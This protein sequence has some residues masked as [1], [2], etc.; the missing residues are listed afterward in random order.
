MNGI[1]EALATWAAACRYDD[2]P[3]TVLERARLQVASVLASVFA[4]ARTEAGRRVLDAAQT[5]GGGAD[6]RVLPEGSGA[7]LFT[8]AYVNAVR[9]VS[10]D[11]DDYLFA[12]HTG[13]SAVLGSLAWG[14]KAG[15][16]GRDVLAA[17][18]VANETGGRLGAAFLLG[19]H[20]GQMWAYIH[21]LEGAVIGA[22]FAGLDAPE[23][24]HAIGI[25]LAQPPYPLAPAFFGP[26]SK[27]LIAAGPLVEG[28]RAASLAEAG[29][30][31][32]DDVIG[33][34][35]GMLAR[36]GPKPFRFPFSA[37][38][39]SWVTE[40]LT[41]K[42]YPGCA[43]VDT[44]VDAMNQIRERFAEKTGRPLA[45]ADVTR[46]RVEATMFTCGMEA[47]SAPHRVSGLVRA[48]DVNFSV[49]LSLGVLIA[50]GRIDAGTLSPASLAEN[51]PAI[52]EIAG[53]TSLDLDPALTAQVG[54]LTEAGID[55]G[56]YLAKGAEP[57][58]LAGADFAAFQMRF[59]SRVT[60]ETS[61]GE[62]F[63]AEVAIPLGGAG[64]PWAET[65]AGVRAKFIENAGHLSDPVAAFERVMAIDEAPDVRE[66]VAAVCAARS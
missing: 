40:S 14:E 60:L 57:A 10:L 45:P 17:Q 7:P 2:L 6:A 65:V 33:A 23:T 18:V 66:V 61:A 46:I 15:A 64:R 21:A 16:P 20:N 36:L 47:M 58:S 53:R 38:G 26:D 63:Q 41:Y 34:A 44:A 55:L 50:A 32:A 30:T 11:F 29:L 51:R 43:Y 39:E 9:S 22:R 1:T 52:E 56:A 27:A 28:L 42:L 24:A 3:A 48:I 59:P 12:G 19:P 37:Y 5:W 13:H 31:G 35:D 62:E 25:A 54:G 49:G 4:G 8:A